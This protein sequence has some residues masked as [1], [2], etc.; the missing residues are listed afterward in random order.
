LV[1]ESNDLNKWKDN[2]MLMNLKNSWTYK[3]RGRDWGSSSVVQ[4]ILSLTTQHPSH[5]HSQRF[6]ASPIKILGGFFF[7]FFFF[8]QKSG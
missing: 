3:T 2:F 8:L 4:C 6:K 5:T 7:F 1:K